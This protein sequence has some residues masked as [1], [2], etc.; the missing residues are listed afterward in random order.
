VSPSDGPEFALLQR[1]IGELFPGAVVAPALVV[2][3]TDARYYHLVADAVYRF[4]PFRF[5][6][7]D[8]R[9]PHGIDER[10]AVAN[11]A[12]AVRFYARL[13]ENASAAELGVR[14]SRT[15]R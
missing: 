1:T 5:A 9:L 13:I 15:G 11:L 2:G 7:A 12:D 6:A 10:I 14:R 8:I 3:G 4:A